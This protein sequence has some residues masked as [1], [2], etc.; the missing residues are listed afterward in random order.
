MSEH[1]GIHIQ[2]ATVCRGLPAPVRLRDWARLARGRKRG[3]ITLRLVDADEG[4]Q[5]NRDFRGR[6]YATNVLSFPFG[7]PGYLGD[8]VICAPV[9]AR[10]AVAQGKALH[11][12]WAHLVVHGVLHLLGHDHQG[13]PEATVMEN[14]ERQL[15]AKM[16][17]ADPY[18]ATDAPAG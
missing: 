13:D 6:D 2:R 10:E 14:R 4:Q 11:A 5:L 18:A 15:L 3:E 9:V 7:E 8:I 1:H 16:G 12:H 17:F